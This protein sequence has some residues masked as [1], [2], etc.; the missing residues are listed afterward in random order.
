MAK[1]NN[2]K[3]NLVWIPLRRRSQYANLYYWSF[4]LTGQGTTGPASTDFAEVI[5]M[6]GQGAHANPNVLEI[7]PT[8]QLDISN[9]VGITA[10]ET[11]NPEYEG[12]AF[13]FT[14]AQL[15]LAGSA[16][17]GPTSLSIQVGVPTLN[18]LSLKLAI[19]TNLTQFWEA[20]GPVNNVSIAWAAQGETSGAGGAWTLK[21]SWV[22]WIDLATGQAPT[23]TNPPLAQ[24]VDGEFSK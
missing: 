16:A 13:E 15:D 1:K 19:G 23:L 21:S 3:P 6:T 4:H 17:L 20:T 12:P 2:L 24:P 9:I 5:F 18:S 10:G 11:L 7:L 22:T 14:G 8:A